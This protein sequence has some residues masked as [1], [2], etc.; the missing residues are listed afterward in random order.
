MADTSLD[1]QEKPVSSASGADAG[2]ADA[3]GG[4]VSE[5]ELSEEEVYDALL[6]ASLS[7]DVVGKSAQVAFQR[8]EPK[9]CV[10][11]RGNALATREG[12]GRRAGRQ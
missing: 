5:L 9:A 10:A 6:G 1:A 7:D 4:G 11:A 3:A 8:L 12:A 2:A